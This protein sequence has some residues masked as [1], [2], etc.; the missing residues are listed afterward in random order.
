MDRTRQ[1]PS[2]PENPGA[3]QIQQARLETAAATSAHRAFA[4]NGAAH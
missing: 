2:E 4:L 1:L 3:Q